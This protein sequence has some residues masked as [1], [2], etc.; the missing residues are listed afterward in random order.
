MSRYRSNGARQLLSGS[1]SGQ[2]YPIMSHE[3]AS[4]IMNHPS[5]M[6]DPGIS[7]EHKDK[8]INSL[9]SPPMPEVIMHMSFGGYFLEV[10]KVLHNPL[11]LEEVC[12][13]Y[14]KDGY[15]ISLVAV[16]LDPSTL[17]F[18]K[19]NPLKN[20]H[21]NLVA[22]RGDGTLMMYVH[23]S[24]IHDFDIIL[25]RN[26][27]SPN[28]YCPKQPLSDKGQCISMIRRWKCPVKHIAN[29]I[30]L[31]LLN[32][33]DVACA[34]VES[35]IDNF[36]YVPRHLKTNSKF[37]NHMIRHNPR[38][39]I[40]VTDKSIIT[41]YTLR[42]ILSSYTPNTSTPISD[43][44]DEYREPF[45]T[46]CANDPRCLPEIAKELPVIFPP[47][48]TILPSH[49][50]HDASLINTLCSINHKIL[51]YIPS[52]AIRNISPDLLARIIRHTYDPIQTILDYTSDQE[53]IDRTLTKLIIV[54]PCAIQHISG[55]PAVI[56]LFEEVVANDPRIFS[57]LHP[58]IRRIESV[59]FKAATE[60]RVWELRPPEYT[61]K[62][63]E[64]HVD[65]IDRIV[66]RKNMRNDIPLSMVQEFLGKGGDNPSR[67]LYTRLCHILLK[68][69]NSNLSA[70][71]PHKTDDYPS[72]CRQ[73]L[74]SDPT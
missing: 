68:S 3:M 30:S 24:F 51:K 19:F 70:I 31:P 10:I 6:L 8:I 32:D 62:F 39:I 22:V 55:Y 36:K 37:I 52:T 7:I 67:A 42:H 23:R 72:M 73:V 53:V 59:L 17:R 18:V 33:Y 11:Y 56:K 50:L 49:M 58:S 20:K 35:D 16:T 28:Y 34:L 48:T 25:A 2:Y 69:S 65:F 21:I 1:T 44:F 54:N 14:K 15:L 61:F 60:I 47:L 41:P 43:L 26:N 57:K 29:Y 9:N 45:T 66:N 46:M 13:I 5:I 4:E 40:H 38:A 63:N 64:D 74:D 27:Y 12:D 71:D